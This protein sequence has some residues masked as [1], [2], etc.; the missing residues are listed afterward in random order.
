MK[1]EAVKNK[2]IILIICLVLIAFLIQINAHSGQRGTV[3][4]SNL[5]KGSY[6]PGEIVTPYNMKYLPI[7]QSFTDYAFYQSIQ[8][9]NNVVIG[10]FKQGNKEII[11]LQDNNNDGKVEIVAHWYSDTNRIDSESEPD[12]Y[13]SAE[14]FKKLKDA[15]VNGRNDTFNLGGKS[16]T[17][18][19]N[20][21]AVSELEALLKTPSNVS[22]SNEGMRISKIDPDELSNEMDIFS[23]SINAENGTVNLA[24]EIKYYHS[25]QS[26]ISPVINMGVYCLRSEDPFAIETVKKINEMSSKYL[27][28]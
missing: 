22:K 15:I 12:K 5:A 19:P 25:G 8:K 7:P 11:L 24:F 1:E 3:I 23:Y 4:Q 18:S 20:K 9:I 13:C 10:K 17:I 21:E 26:R 27:P 16:I 6:V 2:K 14:D 28:K